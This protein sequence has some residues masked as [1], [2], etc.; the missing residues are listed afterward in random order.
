MQRHPYE[1]TASAENRWH[2]DGRGLTFG[3]GRLHAGLSRYSQG[4][5]THGA[6]FRGDSNSCPQHMQLSVQGTILPQSSFLHLTQDKLIPQL[7]H[8]PSTSK[9]LRCSGEAILAP[10]SPPQSG[11]FIDCPIALFFHSSTLD[12]LSRWLAQCA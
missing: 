7:G 5:Y 9:V 2:H 8:C 3:T 6:L 4:G 11:H 1:W 12:L 10:T